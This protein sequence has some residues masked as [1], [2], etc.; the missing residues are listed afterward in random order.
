M[1]SAS[2]ARACALSL[3]LSAVH[4]VHFE[5]QESIVPHDAVTDAVTG[6]HAVVSSSSWTFYHAA[7]VPLLLA[8]GLLLWLSQP[9][10]HVDYLPSGF[11]SFRANYL[12]VWAVAVAADW[13]QGPF[14]YALYESYGYS[15]HEISVL[16]VSGFAASML[17]GTFVGSM[18]DTWGRKNSAMLYCFL[19]TCSCLTKHFQ[20]YWMLMLGRMLGGIA[21]SLLFSTFECWMISE[22]R[23]R[24]GFSEALLKHMFSLMF[25][26]QY[27]VAI[28]T[29]LLAQAAANSVPFTQL[30][31]GGSFHYGGNVIPFDMS[32]LCLVVSAFVIGLTWEENYGDTEHQE[33]SLQSF[34]AGM[35]S[36]RSSWSV[37]GLGVVVA[38][39]EGSMYSFVLNWTPALESNTGAVPHGVIFSGFMMAAMGGSALFG[40]MHPERS[41]TQ[42]LLPVLAVASAAIGTVA[43]VLGPQAWST[44]SVFCMFLIFEACVGIYFPAV[45]ALKSAVVPEKARAGIYNMY[46]VPLNLVVMLLQLTDLPLKTSF[47]AS[48]FLLF[49]AL[50]A[51]VML[52]HIP[53]GDPRCELPGPARTQVQQ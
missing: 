7:L 26:V 17:F 44:A 51:L 14:V 33:S 40:I 50:A 5:A 2:N 8:L 15:P 39:F 36:L 41:P 53:K 16:F 23:Q 38:C 48:S 4:A 19:Y 10:M 30:A 27:A 52:D 24:H 3:L 46:R 28:C 47:A 45:G 32:I 49:L 42:L 11:R 31:A 21:T 18:A 37:A 34:T 13:L 25:L 43:A 29:G 9:K 20:D 12:C 6:A 22:H 35:Q 1:T